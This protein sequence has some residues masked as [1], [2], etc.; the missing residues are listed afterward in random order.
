[1][2]R[3]AKCGLRHAVTQLTYCKHYNINRIFCRHTVGIRKY[4]EI[5]FCRY[6]IIMT[7]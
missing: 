6:T 2:S 3:Y 1:M 4:T 5:M 7:M